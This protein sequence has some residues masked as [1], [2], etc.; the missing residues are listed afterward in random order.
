MGS[1]G[2]PKNQPPAKKK[3]ARSLLPPPPF[4]A[5]FRDLAGAVKAR[6]SGSA[7]AKA[8]Q[9]AKGTVERESDDERLLASR[10]EHSHKSVPPGGIAA[11][12]DACAA[13]PLSDEDAFAASLA[14]VAPLTNPGSRV[15]I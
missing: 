3:E 4:H 1:R 14:G 13:A 9:S 2:G 11:S 12:G 15:R 8:R 5:P 10:T 7:A 6:P